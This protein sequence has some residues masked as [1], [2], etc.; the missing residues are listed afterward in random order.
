MAKNN[1]DIVLILGDF[2]YNGNA[3][4]WWSENMDALNNLNVIAAL[5]NNDDPNDEFLNLWPLNE[6]RWEFIYKVSNVAFVAF[7]TEEN[8]PETID[9]LLAQAQ[10]DPSVDHIIP[11]GHKTVFTP[12]P[13]KPLKPDADREYFD[14]FKKYNKIR[15][16]L[17]GH[18][19]FYA[20][21]NAVPET[22][23][24]YVT[25][26]N[27]GAN[28]HEDSGESGSPPK[29]YVES[30]GALHCDDNGDQISCKMISNEGKVWDDFTITPGN[31][32]A[33]DQDPS[34]TE[35]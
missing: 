32:P 7:N 25:V 34:P 13:G 9:P 11:F 12:T 27:G 3:E 31:H 5:G 18:N 16:I 21:M 1:P 8:D 17:G 24:I 6:G 2:S 20:R 22:N 30:N 26:G 15:M 19:H 35:P 10:A 33:S 4:Q 28:P 23:F 29:Q 14:V